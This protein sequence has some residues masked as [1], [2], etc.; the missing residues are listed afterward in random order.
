MLDLPSRFSQICNIIIPL[1]WSSHRRTRETFK[2]DMSR[3]AF[4]RG[5]GGGIA[6]TAIGALGFGGV[7]QA[8]AADIRPYRLAR[9]VQTRN[10]CPYCSVACGII[11]YSARRHG[12]GRPPRADAY[13][14]RSGSPDQ[15]R[16]ALPQGRGAAGLRPR[17]DAHHG[18]AA[19][20][21]RQQRVQG[22]LLGLRAG[23]HRAGDEGRSRPQLHRQERRRRDGQPLA[24]HRL[25]GRL[26][27]HE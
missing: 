16:H 9:T 23:P 6:V 15:P 24:Q 22:S 2:M 11:M 3:R 27:D 12:E 21:G 18:A 26:G 19:S 13:R 1:M 17:A 10:T 4:L 14:G 5:A 20:R 8:L 7:E 25:P